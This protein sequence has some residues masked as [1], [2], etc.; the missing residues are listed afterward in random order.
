MWSTAEAISIWMEL[1]AERK[2]ELAEIE[3]I[4]P[5]Y[6]RAQFASRISI[7][8][9]DPAYWQASARSWFQAEDRS[10]LKKQKQFMLIVDS[11]EL[12]VSTKPQL[13]ENVQSSWSILAIDSLDKALPQSVQNEAVLLGLSS[14]HLYPAMFELGKGPLPVRVE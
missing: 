12:P 9:E 13:F 14:C 11:T 7:P 6:E 3:E 1:V 2:R 4:D 10:M 5:S 8:R